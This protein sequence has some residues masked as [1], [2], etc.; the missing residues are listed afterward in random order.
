[1]KYLKHEAREYAQEHFRGIWAA[2]PTPF[3][4]DGALD[5]AGLASNIRHWLEDLQIDGLFVGGKQGEYFSMSITE[6][7]RLFSLAVDSAHGRGATILSCS[8]QNLDTLLELAAH[9]IG[10]GADY[11][12]VHSPILHFGEDV[13]STV[14]E[15]YRYIAERVDIGIAM[16]SHPDAGYV[17]SPELCTRIARDC[18]NVVAIKYSVPRDMYAQLTEMAQ[19]SLIVSTASES[20][21]LD[22]IEQLGWRLYLCSI[23][24]ILCQTTVDRRIRT[25]TDLAFRGDWRGA[26]EV[27]QSLE[28][29]RQALRNSRPPGTPHAQQKYWQ[30]LL[31]QVGGR[32]RRPLLNLTQ[33]QKAVIERAFHDCGL[34]LGGNRRDAS[35]EPR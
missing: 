1:M 10:V 30:D 24:P 31:G 15:Y 8:D 5:A 19:G 22:N 18:P 17:M 35:R 12:V 32:V 4:D 9:A 3:L 16:W 34:Q 29:V 7:K 26:R 20:E 33:A 11:I 28:P 21:W 27:Q 2:A 25:Y 13:D 14:Y 23:P 6:R